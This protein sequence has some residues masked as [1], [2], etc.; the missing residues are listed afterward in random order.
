V[1]DRVLEGLSGSLFGGRMLSLLD[2]ALG[3]ESSGGSWSHFGF[4]TN[5]DSRFGR[6]GGGGESES[7]L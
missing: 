7:A 2:S 4:L 5:A 1:Q 3:K 6:L